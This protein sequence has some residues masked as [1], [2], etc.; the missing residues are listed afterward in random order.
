MHQTINKIVSKLSGSWM[1]YG[2]QGT[3]KTTTIWYIANK[4]LHYRKSCTPFEHT[5]LLFINGEKKIQLNDIKQIKNFALQTTTNN[6]VKIV[7]ID[8]S[9]NMNTN[10]SAALLKILEEPPKNVIM[11]LTTIAPSL[12]PITIRSRCIKIALTKPKNA[13]EIIKNAHPDIKKDIMEIALTISN[14]SPGLAIKLLNYNLATVVKLMQS[15]LKNSSLSDL[16]ILLQHIT[17]EQTK[18]ITIVLTYL[19]KNFVLTNSN[20]ANKFYQALQTWDWQKHII[21]NIQ[22]LNMSHHNATLGLL[23]QSINMQKTL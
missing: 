20:D 21:S 13:L 1:L 22:Q 15:I 9:H 10:S 8:N 3:N 2:A 17:D 23:L 19:T 11:L 18:V 5:N 16:P 12:I 6:K 7:A 14:N 4:I